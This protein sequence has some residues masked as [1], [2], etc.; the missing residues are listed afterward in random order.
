MCPSV[1]PL[2]LSSISVKCV[3]EGGRLNRLPGHTDHIN[4]ST[5]ALHCVSFIISLSPLNKLTG[6]TAALLGLLRLTLSCFSLFYSLLFLSSAFL[7]KWFWSFSCP[8]SPSFDSCFSLSFLS[9]FYM[10]M[11]LFLFS[12]FS[13]HFVSSYYNV[14]LLFHH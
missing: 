14:P 11:S 9:L 13:S 10:L 4:S 3:A 2:L 12:S 8:L 1:L 7:F 5:E 6:V